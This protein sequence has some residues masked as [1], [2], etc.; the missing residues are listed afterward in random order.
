MSFSQRFWSPNYSTGLE[1]LFSKLNQGIVE[2]SE[3][4]AL[5]QA[6]AEAEEAHGA[7]LQT[8]SQ[9]SQPK[10][11]GFGKDD[12]ASMK[13]A[14]GAILEQMSEEGKQHEHMAL[15][16]REMVV[17]PF[18]KWSKQHQKRINSSHEFLKKQVKA[19]DTELANVHKAQQ[20][21]FNRCRLEEE[22]GPDSKQDAGEGDL[23]SSS[24]SSNLQKVP[25]NEEPEDSMHVLDLGQGPLPPQES[26]DLI[27][28]M[29]KQIPQIEVKIP[30]LGTYDHCVTGSALC[31]WIQENTDI[32]SLDKAEFAGQQLVNN[33]FLRLVGQVG[34]RFMNSSVCR[35]Q[36]RPQAWAFAG[37]SSANQ[38]LTAM[39]LYHG[40]ASKFNQD[41]ADQSV[42][43]LDLLYKK[44][45]T[46]LDRTRVELEQ[47]V[48][49]HLNY[50]EICER[51]RLS[52][53]KAVLLD[54]A[55]SLSNI[56]PALSAGVDKLLVFHEATDVERDLRY[57]TENYRTGNYSP[58]TVVYDNYYSSTD[59]AAV[60]GLDLE[61]RARADKKRVPI[62]VAAC[63]GCL[64]SAY[65]QMASDKERVA[66]WQQSV[67]SELAEV[68]KVR[69]AINNSDHPTPILSKEDPKVVVQLLKMYFLELPISLISGQFYD[70][71]RS[72][73]QKFGNA[74]DARIQSLQN[75]FIQ[76]PLSHVATLDAITAQ[77]K[78]VVTISKASDD[79]TTLI[80]KNWGPIL[81]RPKAISPLSLDDQFP[82]LILQ[83]LVKYRDDI[84]T[85]LKRNA[86]P[87]NSV[88]K[89]R[90][91]SSTPEPEKVGDRVHSLKLERRRH[92]EDRE[93][94]RDRSSSIKS[95][96]RGSVDG[97]DVSR[98]SSKE[99]N[100]R[101]ERD[102]TDKLA[103]YERVER[104]ERF[105]QM[106]G[107]SNTNVSE[108]LSRPESAPTSKTSLP[109]L[110]PNYQQ[111]QMDFRNSQESFDA[112]EER[113]IEE[114]N[115]EPEFQ[116]SNQE[117]S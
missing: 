112:K 110:S 97:S 88:R 94:P 44:A 109:S 28:H 113:E 80:C 7:R 111:K 96:R 60:F 46:I 23:N 66:L 70:I 69:E 55:A 63:L 9:N 17:A 92:R 77:M 105:D 1:T 34:S 67:Q 76:L 59:G 53:F 104:I 18:D 117:F 86:V 106:E 45:V 10:P 68:F 93:K 33:G 31:S 25:L 5:A 8:I 40:L 6:R 49:E 37:F 47:A 58:R 107:G 22:N 32:S 82:A 87:A 57:L 90:S 12:G 38:S 103:R 13:N 2:N 85:E 56:V 43:E 52:A 50:L 29:L 11:Q 98:T 84:F 78:R 61:L 65:P 4:L 16:I 74:D 30:I 15:A 14:Y 24:S 72:I 116:D 75:V 99:S 54:F 19:Y 41:S 3:L 108:D 39:E 91:A 89:H 64:D 62:I 114:S 48:F 73:Y 20:R 102:S 36:W 95:S 100:E 81:C 115:A 42:R 21:Y 35:Y 83:D 71:L 27:A 26:Q 51:E 101:P 79:D